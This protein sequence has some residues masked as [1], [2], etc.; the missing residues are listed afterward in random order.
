MTASRLNTPGANGDH[1][2]SHYI[3]STVDEQAEMLSA[4]GIDNID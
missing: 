2:Q 1:F 3:P 4:L